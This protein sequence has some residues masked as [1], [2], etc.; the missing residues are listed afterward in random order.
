ML[1]LKQDRVRQ[2]GGRCRTK[3]EGH[4]DMK[5]KR[6]T[7][8]R[9][10]WEMRLIAALGH[11]T[12][13]LFIVSQPPRYSP[14]IFR[15]LVVME[16]GK[17]VKCTVWACRILNS[18]RVYSACVL[19]ANTAMVS[20]SWVTLFPI[21]LIRSDRMGLARPVK[22]QMFCSN[23]TSGLP[24]I[25]SGGAC[26]WSW[27]STSFSKLGTAGDDETFGHNS[28]R[29]SK[30]LSQTKNSWSF[31]LYGVLLLSFNNI[32]LIHDSSQSS[33]SLS[34]LIRNCRWC[35]LPVL[36]W[37]EMYVVLRDWC[38]EYIKDTVVNDWAMMMMEY[39]NISKNESLQSLKW[40]I[41]ALHFQR[42]V[43]PLFFFFFLAD[44][45]SHSWVVEPVFTVIPPSCVS[46]ESGVYV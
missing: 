5:T 34:C 43:G 39:K 27:P 19:K 6:E 12:E 25:P 10:C 9:G 46:V 2:R 24:E 16:I 44:L 28:G 7:E 8:R 1:A 11:V 21:S 23:V 17:N 35:S 38:M 20:D 33:L 18:N 13:A 29:T 3:R 4:W 41:F 31:I 15:M 22:Q 26:V 32:H 14:G 42:L 37:R 45:S 36:V 30:N 40:N